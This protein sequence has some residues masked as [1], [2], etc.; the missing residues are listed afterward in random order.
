LY[1][2]STSFFSGEDKNVDGRVKP[3]HDEWSQ[4]GITV[5]RRMSDVPDQSGSQHG[6]RKLTGCKPRAVKGGQ[7]GLAAGILPPMMALLRR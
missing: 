4:P 6:G 2:A 5:R 7:T 3:G 1:R